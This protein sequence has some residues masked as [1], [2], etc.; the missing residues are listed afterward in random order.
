MRVAQGC[1]EGGISRVRGGLVF[2]ARP[3]TNLP[4]MNQDTEAS[5][6][7]WQVCILIRLELALGLRSPSNTGSQ[8]LSLKSLLAST[9]R[10]RHFLAHSDS[11]HP[12]P[13]K[14]GTE[15][16][17]LAACPGAPSPFPEHSR[18]LVT[19]PHETKAFHHMASKEKNVG[20][21]F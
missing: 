5:R 9:G 11:M 16:L 6:R 13:H 8:L 7:V 15:P 18:H 1:P 19:H 21:G 12:G 3:T 4:E 2:V 17:Y 14:K 20:M 10:H